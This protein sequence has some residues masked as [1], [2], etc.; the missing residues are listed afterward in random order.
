MKKK[1]F[2]LGPP[3]ESRRAALQQTPPE[4]PEGL[5]KPPKSPEKSP[6][7]GSSPDPVLKAALDKARTKRGLSPIYGAP[8]KEISGQGQE[9]EQL[10]AA[11]DVARKRCKA[12]KWKE[13]AAKPELSKAEM[14]EGLKRLFRAAGAAPSYKPD[15][16]PSFDRSR[17]KPAKPGAPYKKQFSGGASRPGNK[18]L[19][20]RETGRLKRLSRLGVTF[21]SN[22]RAEKLIEIL[23][24]KHGPCRS[25]KSGNGIFRRP[26]NKKS[27]FRNLPDRNQ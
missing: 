14:K 18:E 5:A 7:P 6:A 15:G 12:G 16:K 25:L 10:K 17:I 4:V 3:S 11:L 13:A 22:S 1:L 27:L 21:V 8:S 26:E 9:K 2:F 23:G 19:A 24:Q 20:L